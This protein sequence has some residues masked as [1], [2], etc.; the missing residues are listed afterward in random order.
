MKV[1]KPITSYEFSVE[2]KRNENGLGLALDE[3]NMSVKRLV[4]GC[5]A[6]ELGT[7]QVGDL[8]ISV[9]NENDEHEYAVR[10]N[11]NISMLFPP[12]DH[13]FKLRFMRRQRADPQT[14]VAKPSLRRAGE[15]Q[16][17]GRRVPSMFASERA[18]ALPGP[19]PYAFVHTPVNDKEA[20]LRLPSGEH[21]SIRITSSAFHLEDVLWLPT[22][23]VANLAD[24]DIPDLLGKDAKKWQ[25]SAMTVS[26]AGI[27]VMPAADGP[28]GGKK[29]FLAVGQ[30][31][32]SLWV[33]HSNQ[34]VIA[35]CVGAPAAAGSHVL[36][37]AAGSLKLATTWLL[38]LAGRLFVSDRNVNDVDLP[39]LIAAFRAFDV[40]GG[41]AISLG[42]TQQVA[43][44]LGREIGMDGLVHLVHSLGVQL[45]LQM[46]LNL[47][48]AR[49]SRVTA[50]SQMRL[51]RAAVA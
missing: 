8:L 49:H 51:K 30:A 11:D 6:A 3:G 46:T 41:D 4:P 40:D 45:T 9:Q 37:F 17:P 25:L 50:A 1:L 12:G 21:T 5:A 42:E 47:A 36:L 28:K 33:M 19:G 29:Q 44:A 26:K 22:A 15:W 31:P 39:E 20:T 16:A 38:L 7:L 14:S 2:L 27:S 48:Q 23:E 43:R 18:C 24:G 13:T 10:A 35:L 32:C 34:T